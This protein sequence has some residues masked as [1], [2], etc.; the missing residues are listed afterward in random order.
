MLIRCK[1]GT[2]NSFLERLFITHFGLLIGFEVLRTSLY[3]RLHSKMC[4][5]Y[6]EW[7]QELGNNVWQK[8]SGIVSGSIW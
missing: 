5:D 1:P 6:I 3:L 7:R 4:M 2:P 8:L